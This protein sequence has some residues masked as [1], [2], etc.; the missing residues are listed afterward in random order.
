M[1]ADSDDDD[2]DDD[3]YNFKKNYDNGIKVIQ[4]EV[5]VPSFSTCPVMRKSHMS[6]RI[7]LFF[8]CVWRECEH[9]SWKL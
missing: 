9:W 7:S 2:D 6:Y 1:F 5:Q 3:D 8:V 4:V